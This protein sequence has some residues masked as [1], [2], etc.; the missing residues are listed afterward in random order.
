[1]MIMNTRSF[2]RPLLPLSLIAVSAAAFGQTPPQPNWG[3]PGTPVATQAP[4]PH[5]LAPVTG[6]T[7]TSAANALPA[8]SY[9]LSLNFTSPA[10]TASDN[11]TITRSGNQ[12]N[13]VLAPNVIMAGNV[14]ANGTVTMTLNQ[15]GTQLQLTGSA[16]GRTASGQV[17]ATSSGHS[18]TGTFTLGNPTVSAQM[19]KKGAP[20]DC[21]IICQLQKIL[22]CIATAGVE[23]D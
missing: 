16:S 1:M 2:L 12:I 22:H 18:S 20:P 15:T 7:T 11:V 23:C 19:V 8:G 9:H 21:G 14:A 3:T 17:T 10:K 5:V 6:I 13:V 4:P